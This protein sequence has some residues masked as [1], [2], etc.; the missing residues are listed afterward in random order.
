MNKVWSNVYLVKDE[1]IFVYKIMSTT[2]TTV[3]DKDGGNTSIEY[4]LM[5]KELTGLLEVN[6]KWIDARE[7]DGNIY[8]T[9]KEAV[10]FIER[11]KE[12]RDIVK[13]ADSNKT[14]WKITNTDL[15]DCYFS[16]GTG[17]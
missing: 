16:M 1:N 11:I 6:E 13:D 9:K 7:G 14:G 17:N 4:T 2:E 5:R 8:K 15:G 10:A 3:T 12:A